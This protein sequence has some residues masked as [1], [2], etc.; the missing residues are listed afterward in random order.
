MFVVWLWISLLLIL[1]G[2]SYL[3]AMCKSTVTTERLV[4]FFVLSLSLVGCNK[5]T[6]LIVVRK[7][8]FFFLPH[9]PYIQFAFYIVVCASNGPIRIYQSGCQS[10]RTKWSEEE[11][12]CVCFHEMCILA[13]IFMSMLLNENMQIL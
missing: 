7:F 5:W 12:M 2:P 3:H 6:S 10:T 4:D 11:C 9:S 1:S 13:C 8:S